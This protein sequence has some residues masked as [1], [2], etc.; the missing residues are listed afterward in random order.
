MIQR[1][2]IKT[3]SFPLTQRQPILNNTITHARVAASKTSVIIQKHESYTHITAVYGSRCRSVTIHTGIEISNQSETKRIIN[4][5][6]IEKDGSE[7]DEA[8]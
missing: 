6:N 1:F 5:K 3:R 8:I 2:N 4:K 7:D